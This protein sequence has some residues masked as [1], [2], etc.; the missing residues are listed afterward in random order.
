MGPV[1][2]LAMRF[3]DAFWWTKDHERLGFLLA[4][5]RPFAVLWTTYPV[6]APLLIAWSAGP[7]AMP[8]VD[9]SDEQILDQGLRTIKSVFKE[10]ERAAQR[11]Q[12][13]Y[14]HNWQ[15]D[16]LAG[17]AYSYVG[18]GGVGSQQLLAQPVAGTLFFAGEA[19]VSNGHHA[20]VHGALA[21]GE[22]A[23]REVL[24]EG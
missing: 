20:T 4:P 16:P 5:G 23:A 13:W 11:L 7:N 15:K 1:I 14:V 19:T 21:S 17:G 6:V 24:G 9:L 2:K 22:R 10:K 8:L 12:S 3:D 18:V